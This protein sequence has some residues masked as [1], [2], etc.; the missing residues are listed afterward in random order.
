MTGTATR[1]RLS[2]LVAIGAFGVHQLRYLF[3]YGQDTRPALEH[4]GHGYLVAIEPL[5]GLALAGVLGHVLWRL[6]SGRPGRSP[7][8]RRRLAWTFGLALLA[9][10]VGQ[11]L[12]EGQ[13]AQGHA[14][15]WTG[16]FGSGGWLAVPLALVIGGALSFCIT[17]VA[18]AT[19]RLR[20]AGCIG[21]RP[22]APAPLLLHAADVKLATRELAWHLA[23]RGPPRLLSP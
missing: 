23:G 10:Y 16:V 21:R 12:I 17:L 4:S 22:A 14:S 1:M 9:V 19:E 3:A 15:G 13:L 18:R 2:A 6:A 7:C 20:L 8:D 5:I 11:E